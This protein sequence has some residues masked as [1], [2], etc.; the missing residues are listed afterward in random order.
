MKPIVH[1]LW[2][3]GKNCHHETA[4][5]F[6]EAGADPRII[7]LNR[8]LSGKVKLS[9]CDLFVLGGGFGW[10]DD[11]RS[12]VISAIDLMYPLG[13]EMEIML[14]RKVPML[15]IC[16]GFQE[17]VCTGLIN[18]NFRH[19]TIMLDHNRSVTYEHWVTTKV[20]F[21][22]HPGCVWTEDL[23]GYTAEFP[24]AHGEGVPV[25]LGKG[26]PDWQVA[27]TYGSYEGV[28]DYPVSPNGSPIA[29]LSHGNIFGL[30]PHPE[31]NRKS[32]IFIFRNGVKAVK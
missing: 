24:V 3:P 29:G 6:K 25:Y 2:L 5:L 1:I 11:I 16:N 32:G 26:T 8:A 28:T 22:H 9:D 13:E 12:G 7:L 18:G 30:M 15:G 31:R 19:P 17:L 10:N 4:F 20:V 14:E 27:A 21:H 23:D